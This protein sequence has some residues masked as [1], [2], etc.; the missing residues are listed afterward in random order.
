MGAVAS[1]NFQLTCR[2]R[3]PGREDVVVA[4]DLD[5][6]LYEAL[7]A[8]GRPIA[9]ACTGDAVCGKCTV[10]VLEGEDLVTPMDD[11]EADVLEAQGAEPGMR[12]ACR[13]RA[14][15]DGVVVG[16]DYW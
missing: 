3:W 15:G 8:G 14:R 16:T 2:S 7:R 4:L 13:A 9:S 5:R 6:T 11:E 10:R 12:L 1:S